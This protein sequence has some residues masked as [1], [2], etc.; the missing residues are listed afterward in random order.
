MPHPGPSVVPIV[1]AVLEDATPIGLG[2]THV[3]GP[4]G[5]DRDYYV[6]QLKDWNSPRR[7]SR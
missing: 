1:L 3:T 7:S 4:D 6:R 2:W 5:V